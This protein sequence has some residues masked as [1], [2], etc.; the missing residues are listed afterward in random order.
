MSQATHDI[1]PAQVKR[2]LIYRLGSLGDTVVAL[3]SLHLVRQV[4][5]HAR[6]L[7]LTNV[8]VHAKAPAASAILDGSG[9]V[10]GYLRYPVGT[11]SVFELG[12]VWWAIRRFR[13]EV[14][15][16]LT[17]FRGE[18]VVARDT[19]F[20]RFAGIRH[21]VGLPVGD[22]AE[23]RYDAE[24]RLWE[25]EA[26]RLLRCMRP[27]GEV[28]ID[29]LRWWDLCLTEREKQ[30]AEAVLSPV[31]G[32][33]VIACGPGT[34][35]QAKDWGQENWRALLARLSAEFPRYG[36]VL[37]GAREDAEA[38]K[39]AAAEW[40]G[41]VVNLCGQLTP[42]ESAAVLAHAELFLGPDSGPM[43]LAA[44]YGVPCAIAFA[45][46]ARRGRWFPVGNQNRP[47]YH[48]V[49]CANCGLTTCMEQKKRCIESI[50]VDEMFAAAMEAWKNGRGERMSPEGDQR[51]PACGSQRPTAF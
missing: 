7:M 2:V 36:L 24:D 45:A 10:H 49:E 44:A 5:P 51:Q 3:P 18:E 41:P 32:Q 46:V 43:H 22:A 20:F 25:R 8:P 4:F 48:T 50:T 27:L 33:P 31:A 28:D 34:K 17:P 13:P 42:R 1:D 26:S 21:I 39:Y 16:Y 37:I 30:K 9:L 40:K 11:R 15:V 23:S 47:V 12:R 35:M 6:R 29:D 38:G 14:L 19:K